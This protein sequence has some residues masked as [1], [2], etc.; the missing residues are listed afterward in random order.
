M[1]FDFN[2]IVDGF[3][4]APAN[5]YHNFTTNTQTQVAQDMIYYL[6]AYDAFANHGPSYS[7]VT[8]AQATMMNAVSNL[9][10]G[11]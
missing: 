6:N 2:S 9:I 11:L 7:A 10:N 3:L 1:F 5:I 8:N 4:S